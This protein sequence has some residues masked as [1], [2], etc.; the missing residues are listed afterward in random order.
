MAELDQSRE[1]SAPALPDEEAAPEETGT[2]PSVVGLILTVLLGLVILVALIPLVLWVDYGA[3]L[4][5]F[6][7]SAPPAGAVGVLVALVLVNLVVFAAGRVRLFRR[8]QLVL[9]YVMLMTGLPVANVGLVQPVFTEMTNVASEYV[10]RRV[11]SVAPAYALQSRTV[12][13]KVGLE[14]ELSKEQRETRVEPLKRFWSG[15]GLGLQE[16]YRLRDMTT[17][18]KLVFAWHKIPWTLWMWP[19]VNWGIFLLGL[20]LSIMFLVEILRQEWVERENLAFPLAAA[21]AAVIEEGSREGRVGHPLLVNWLFWLGLAVPVALLLLSGLRYYQKYD[22]PVGELMIDFRRVF[23][24]APWDAIKTN[25]LVLSPI[26]LGIGYLVHLEISRSI[27]IFFL[28]GT[29]FHLLAANVGWNVTESPPEPLDWQMPR[30]PFPRDQGIG[31]MMV[32][33]LFLLW[34]S[35]GGLWALVRAPFSHEAVR[36]STPGFVPRRLAGWGFLGCFVFLF[37][38][39][40][41]VLM[42]PAA[43]APGEPMGAPGYLLVFLW[44]VL[45]YLMIVAFARL[46]A[47]AGI[48]S[49][50]L[51]PAAVRVPRVWGGP[52]VWGWRSNNLLNNHFSWMT[53]ST[54]PAM[55]PLQLEGLEVA[56]RHGPSPR[57]IGFGV[58]AAFVTALVFGALGFLWMAYFQGEGYFHAHISTGTMP[59]WAFYRTRGKA[60]DIGYIHT[61]EAVACVVGV[62]VMA[63]L[64]VARSKWLRFPVHP[65][66]YLVWCLAPLHGAFAQHQTVTHVNMV[67]GPMLIAWF[68]K[69]TV[70]R[71][72]GMKLYRKLLPIAYGMIIGHLLMYVFWTL[73]HAYF[74]YGGGDWLM[75]LP[76]QVYMPEAY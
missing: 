39:M 24:K 16:Q 41:W 69:R 70:I 54:L 12:F 10:N 32:V 51:M 49:N 72:G 50:Y 30:Y 25:V 18:Q 14:K 60:L 1:V 11:P 65:L 4:S 43:G 66:G 64:L 33:A 46:R 34:R 48:P 2:Q 26:L 17:W 20:F 52:S 68:A 63:M 59:L 8:W 76:Q 3:K 22:I 75:S 57:A 23:T 27:W 47:E 42:E 7:T 19:L 28:V 9:L 61:P 44:L 71:Y 53:M 13:P 31:A 6:E 29:L 21:P 58:L 55:A 35:R 56:R 45:F 73:A 5:F 15:I 67:W 38:W 62:A 40:V 74:L 37:A 36:S